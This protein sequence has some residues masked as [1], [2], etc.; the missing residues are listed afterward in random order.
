MKK[1]VTLVCAVMLLASAG[2]MSLTH[3]VG[4][5]AQGAGHTEQRAWYAIWGLVPLNQ[6]DSRAMAGGAADYTV[7]SEQSVVDTVLNMF[8]SWITV[9]CQT[10]TVTK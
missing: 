5:G 10:V 3:Q 1:V 8:T 2:C 4:K 9:Y 7:K 6:V